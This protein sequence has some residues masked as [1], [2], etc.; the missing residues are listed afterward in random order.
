LENVQNQ[1][2]HNSI[3]VA[4]L[5]RGVDATKKRE[6]QQ[7]WRMDGGPAWFRRNI[8]SERQA[9]DPNNNSVLMTHQQDAFDGPRLTTKGVNS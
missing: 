7:D 8:H 3:I 6:H 2:Y 1:L 4:R 9:H 5:L